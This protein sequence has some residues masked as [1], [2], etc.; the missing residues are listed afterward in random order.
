MNLIA[1]YGASQI[2]N[3]WS[4]TESVNHLK[5]KAT[6]RRLRRSSSPPQPFNPP[7]FPAKVNRQKLPF[8]APLS[9]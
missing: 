3:I 7:R 5:E 6:K 8:G 9:Y 1:G 2:N 4:Q